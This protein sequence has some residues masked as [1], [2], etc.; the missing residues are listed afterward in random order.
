M[1]GAPRLWLVRHARP[2]IDA[3]ICYGRL[4]VAADAGAT[5]A[6]AQA[7]AAALPPRI[8]AL[9][10]SPLQRCE[11]LAQTLKALRPDLMMKIEPRIQEL[12]FGRWEGQRW[13]A[14]GAPAVAA[15]SA[16]L[17]RHAP[18]GGEAL[19]AMLVR[20]RSAWQQAAAQAR[21][22]GADVV[23][24]SHAGVA[25]CLHWLRTEGERAPRAEDWPPQAPTYGAWV[26]L[27][28]A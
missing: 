7:L 12:D 13:D 9:H 2:L 23:W 14:I 8:A 5:Q 19:A 11:Q 16:D 28:L 1:N 20:V 25:R 18:G 6:A 3:G 26:C 4:D 17:A 21:Q 22:T 15:W 24:I 27:P 10:T